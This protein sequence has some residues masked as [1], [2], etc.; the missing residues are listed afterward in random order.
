V[1]SSTSSFRALPDGW[2]S[3]LI[4]ALFAIAALGSYE[5]FWRLRGFRPSLT[6]N[7]A[8]WCEARAKVES[9]AIVLIGSSRLQLGIDPTLLG[10]TLGGKSVV[11]LALEGA[12]F[13]PALDDLAADDWFHGTVVIEYMPRHWFTFDAFS[14]GRAQEFLR[15][16]LTS[17]LVGPIENRL[18]RH[19]DER[20]ALMGPELQLMSLLSYVAKH[21]YVPASNHEVLRADRSGR[22][23]YAERSNRSEAQFWERSLSQLALTERFDHLRNDVAAIRRRGG[24][25]V[26]Y[27]SPIQS[28]V[29]QD[30]DQRFPAREWLPRLTNALPVE[31]IDFDAWPERDSFQF[32]DGEH[33]DDADVPRLTAILAR[34]LGRVVQY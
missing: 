13:V 6:N 19:L 30:E 20:L 12:S 14:R 24:R 21:H 18:S 25:I 33:P 23:H 11:D 32:P 15:A 9:D 22:L 4:A 1:H 5:A 3:L 2:S 31:L 7:E 8:L 26:V 34:E 28:T 27:R 29:L 17:S 10:E 16:C